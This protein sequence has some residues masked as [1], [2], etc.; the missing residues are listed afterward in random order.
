MVDQVMNVIGPPAGAAGVRVI[1]TIGTNALSDPRY[2]SI[3]IA[4]VAKRGPSGVFVPISS[5]SQYNN[6]YG[7]PG[8]PLWHLFQDGSQLGPDAIDG[9]YTMSAGAGQVWLCRLDLDGKGIRAEKIFKNRHGAGVLKIKAANEG[10][11]GGQAA[12]IPYSPVIFASNVT[13]TIYAPGVLANQ[14][15]GATANFTSGSGKGYTIV[16]NTEASA[17]GEAVFTIGSQYDLLADGINGPVTISGT[18]SYNVFTNITGVI[19]FPLQIPATGVVN[20]NG[21]VITGV[22]T[23]FLADYHVG[24]NIYFL[25]ESRVVTSITSNTTMTIDQPF[26]TTVGT[27]AAIAKDNLTITGTGTQ[28]VSELAVGDNLYVIANGTTYS[29]KVT[30]ITSQTSLTL[31]SGFPVDIASGTNAAIDNYWVYGSVTS[32]YGIDLAIGDNIID[33]NRAAQA[34]T[35]LEIDVVNKKF[36]IGQK[37][38]ASFTNAQLTKQSQLASVTLDNVPGNGITVSIG[39]GQKYPLTHFSLSFGFNGKALFT[40]PD[41]SLD[42]SDSL[43]VETI[44][45]NSNI[46]YQFGGV[47][48]QTWVT[49]ESLWESTYTTAPSNDVR[50][51]NGAGTVTQLTPR[52]VYTAAQFDYT[53]AVGAIFLPQPYSQPRN[54][55]RIIGAV[56]P[57]VL[58][59]TISSTGVNVNGTNTNFLS[60]FENGDYLYDPNTNTSVQVLTVNSDTSLTLISVFSEDIPS[61]TIGTKAGYLVFDQGIDMTKRTAI[62]NYFAVVFSETLT[63]GYDGDLSS[64]VPYHYTKFFDA[65]SNLLESS[66]FGQNLGL[67]RMACPGVT[68]LTVQGQLAN[69]ASQKAFEARLTIPSYINTAAEAEAYVQQ[70]LGTSDYISIAF[71][72]YAEIASPYGLGTRLIDISGDIMGKESATATLYQG[73]HFPTA[74]IGARLTR[75][76]SLPFS[77]NPNDEAILNLAGIQPIKRM[78]G[79]IVIFGDRVPY[80]NSLYTFLHIRRIQSNYVRVFLEARMLLESLFKP[81]QPELADQIVMVLESFARGEYRKGVFNQFLTF[82]QAVNVTAE[83]PTS[84]NTG[85]TSASSADSAD[86]IVSIINGKLYIYWSYVPTGVLEQLYIYAGPDILTSGYGNGN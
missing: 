29:R 49:A 11:W 30:A 46:A 2:G 75:I 68:D 19:T 58:E 35:I 80:V 69:Y 59:G 48:Y 47:S 77:P 42:S 21:N 55:L 32:N 62:N 44:V 15:I 8:N 1:E 10:C 86:V 82:Q 40:I 17:G 57:I 5:R 6:I 53:N 13:F 23:T 27:N 14:F 51:F 43:F 76:T 3:A 56:A 36:R 54:Q 63:G 74:G 79:S 61:G 38:S 45:N 85:A 16:A 66:V 84:S 67:I 78:L 24:H 39:L 33:P 72:S 60:V 83:T 52:R 9:F 73:Y 81:N 41:A 26:T 25:G 12:S 31:A 34:V 70:A 20:I 65:D 28:F 7:D 64:I 4:M 71:P 50:P 22:G 18:A 37:F